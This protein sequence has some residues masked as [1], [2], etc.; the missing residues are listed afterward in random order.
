MNNI[1][2]F[3][4]AWALFATLIGLAEFNGD[5]QPRYCIHGQVDAG[6]E[7]LV[8]LLDKNRKVR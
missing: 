7:D 4:M 8:T 6:G 1:G 2:W 5:L 3:F